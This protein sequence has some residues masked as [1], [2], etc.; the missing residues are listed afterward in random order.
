MCRSTKSCGAPTDTNFA[1]EPNSSSICLAA[2]SCS[3]NPSRLVLTSSSKALDTANATRDMLNIT[4]R[5]LCVPLAV[6]A[7]LDPSITDSPVEH[8]PSYSLLTRDKSRHGQP[9]L[10]KEQAA[11]EILRGPRVLGRT[12]RRFF[13]TRRR[14]SR[15]TRA[16][17]DRQ[18]GYLLR[19][20]SCTVGH[21]FVPCSCLP[22]YLLRLPSTVSDRVSMRMDIEA[23]VWW[24]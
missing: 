18:V 3:A 15:L 24:R 12:R 10:G 21:R 13:G 20:M 4:V 7:S 6:A 2:F 8:N 14:S 1:L 9:L 5:A 16:A 23:A 22:G 19:L 17:S 11:F